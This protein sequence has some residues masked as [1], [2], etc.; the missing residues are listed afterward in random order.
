MFPVAPKAKRA[1]AR[2]AA[3]LPPSVP[4]CRLSASPMAE[5]V[6]SM[7]WPG[8][9]KAG[10]SA[11]TSTAAAFLSPGEMPG[12]AMIDYS[13]K[14]ARTYRIMARVYHSHPL[15][16]SGAGAVLRAPSDP[17]ICWTNLSVA[18]GRESDGPRTCALCPRQALIQ[19]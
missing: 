18:P 1:A 16:E 11:V 2:V 9:A 14:D 10:S 6:T 7:R 13:V 19:A 3:G 5:T 8:L 4:P 12:G 17:S 15:P